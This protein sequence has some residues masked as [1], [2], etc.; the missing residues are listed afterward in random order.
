MAARNWP[1]AMQQFVDDELLRGPLL[2]DQVVEGAIDQL[3]R[4]LPAL[5]LGQRTALSD[6]MQSLQAQRGRV[7]E[8]FMISLRRQVGETLNRPVAPEPAKA[9]RMQSLALVD[10]D[11]VAVNVEIA[12]A[13]EIVKS[14]AE[15]EL[16]ELQTYTAA[17]AGDMDMAQ[18]NN[19]FRP[20]TYANALWAGAQALPLS[21]GHQ[22]AFMRHASTPLAQLLRRSYAAACSR[23]E[24]MGV[25]PAAYRTMIL[26]SGSRRGSRSPEVGV[27]FDLHRIRDS[28][29]APVSPTAS[30]SPHFARAAPP[31]RETWRAVAAS[32][33]NLVDR[34]AVELVSRLF[35]AMAADERVPSDVGLIVSRLQGPALRLSLRDPTLLDQDQHP[36]WRFIN[37]LVFEAQM[38]PDAADPERAL[39]L[40][41]AQL[42]VDQVASEP[43]QNAGLYR[44]ALDRMQ[45][46]LN[47]G[48]TRRLGGVSSQ[49]GALHR[50]E[51]R[52]TAGNVV[53]STLHGTLDVPQL[54]TVPAELLDAAPPAPQAADGSRAW[55]DALAPGAWVRMFLQGRWH[56]AR[57][58]WVGDRR[59]IWLFGDGASDATWAVRRSALQLMHESKLAKTLQRRSIVGTAAARVQH[60]VVAAAAA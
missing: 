31:V 8:Y 55:L 6:L 56:H 23:L 46:V 57:L 10:E 13:V 47:K 43:E 37:D 4:A 60:Q 25:E 7:S 11:E 33:P 2:L 35:D 29:P 34:Q 42:A 51:D 18:L 53:P 59:E 32:A 15:Y 9:A 19:P 12:H 44:W 54:D 50:V 41:T 5:A 17:L 36:L 48:L 3:R 1:P 40:K 27:E 28:M 38:V 30:M 39:L 52:L 26:P 14:L 22:I 58:L 16:R 21:R 24:S 49:I 20:E 45:S